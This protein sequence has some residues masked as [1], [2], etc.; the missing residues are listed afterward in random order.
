MQSRNGKYF[1]CVGIGICA[2]DHLALLPHFPKPD[3]KLDL[4]SFSVQGGGP[5]PTA[6]ATMGRFG[7]RVSFV[8]KVGSDACGRQV[9]SEL[10]GFGVDVSGAV[11]DPHSRT[12]RAYI[13]IDSQTAKR[14]VVLDRSNTAN[15]QPA[16]IRRDLLQDGRLLLTDARETEA[17][18][19]AV[20]LAREARSQV[21]LDLGNV[22][23][24]TEAFLEL[25]DYPVVSDTF[26]QRF[27]GDDDPVAA[28]RKLLEFGVRAAVVTCGIGGSYFAEAGPDVYHQPAFRVEALDTTGAGDVYHGAFVYALAMGETIAEAVRFAS[29]AAALKC[30][31]VGGRAGIPTLQEVQELLAAQSETRPRKVS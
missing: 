22:R 3:E 20:E 7:A 11:I 25:A 9:L 24:R 31:Q 1:D 4:L 15:L 23:E 10:E 16:E 21:V 17:C 13:W 28:V 30:R 29:A 2:L 12:A 8:G 26:A 27:F 5:V 6:L 19:R 18:L 14:T